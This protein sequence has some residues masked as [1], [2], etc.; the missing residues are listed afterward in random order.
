[1]S[2][3]KKGTG[4]YFSGEKQTIL[5]RVKTGQVCEDEG[6]MRKK[7]YCSAQIILEYLH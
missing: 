5:S 7:F 6:E 4:N 1:M 3:K 2:N